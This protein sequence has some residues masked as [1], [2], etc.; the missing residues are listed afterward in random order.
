MSR[1]FKVAVA[2]DAWLSACLAALCMRHS[3]KNPFAVFV[4]VSE[5]ISHSSKPEGRKDI[6]ASKLMFLVLRKASRSA[7]GHPT[8]RMDLLSPNVCRSR[9]ID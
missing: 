1:L 2:F 8:Y 6:H 7:C 5:R 9:V 4:A 3:K